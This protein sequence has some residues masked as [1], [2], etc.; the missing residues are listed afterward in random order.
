MYL[1]DS[2]KRNDSNFDVEINFGGEWIS[3]DVFFVGI[4]KE[5]Q[6]ILELKND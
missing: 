4:L 5:G 2:F 6:N 1:G 3:L